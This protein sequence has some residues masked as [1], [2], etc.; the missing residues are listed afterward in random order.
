MRTGGS[1][2]AITE[3]MIRAVR[4]TQNMGHVVLQ[5]SATAAAAAAS[6]TPMR[7][8]QFANT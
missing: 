1:H 7:V 8:I 6:N 3:G 4:S 5:D 2:Y